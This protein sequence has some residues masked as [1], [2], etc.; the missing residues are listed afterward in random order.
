MKTT[1][2]SLQKRYTYADYLN[3]M[4]DVRR[5][6]INGI[7]KLMTP[8]PSRKHQEISVNLTW[9]FRSFTMHKTCKVYHAPSDVR[10]PKNEKTKNDRDIYTV[11]QPDL[12]VVC[13]LSKLDDKGCL[14]APDFIIEIVSPER[15]KRDV[16]EKFDLYEEHGVMEYWIVNPHDENVNVFV[17]DDNGKYQFRGIFAGDDKIPVH[18]FNGDLKVDLTEVFIREDRQE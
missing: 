15:A 9:I 17:L 8:A 7:V 3:W 6:L 14:G 2:L 11:V 13:D 1:E 16:R 18:I 10:F 5:E 4:D 12:Y